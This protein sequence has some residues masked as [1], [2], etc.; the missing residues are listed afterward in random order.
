MLSVESPKIIRYFG[1]NQ[2]I[3]F[4]CKGLL[5]TV[6]GNTDIVSNTELPQY[7]AE[8]QMYLYDT[9]KNPP[10]KSYNDANLGMKILVKKCCTYFHNLINI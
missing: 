5:N 8:E 2:K 3:H 7:I 6:E 4:K 10:V 1:I 9:R